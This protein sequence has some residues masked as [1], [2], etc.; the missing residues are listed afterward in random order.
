MTFQAELQYL[1]AAET[2]DMAAIQR[3]IMEDNVNIN[4]LDHMGRSALEL[5]LMGGHVAVVEHLLP[6]S[7]LQCVEDTLMYAIEKDNVKMCELILEHPLYRC[8][9]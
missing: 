4:C 7:N 5:A 1:L 8:G 3:S 2:G 6:R 9:F